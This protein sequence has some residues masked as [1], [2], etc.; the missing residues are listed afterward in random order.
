MKFY[1]VKRK[2]KLFR[3]KDKKKKLSTFEKIK[4]FNFNYV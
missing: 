1:G 3:R 2:K 4:F